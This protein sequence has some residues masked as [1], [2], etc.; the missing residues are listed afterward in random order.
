MTLTQLT[1][2][3]P[4]A[5]VAAAARLYANTFGFEI[6][7]ITDGHAYLARDNAAIRLIHAPDGTDFD[8]PA[9]Q[10]ALYIDCDDVETLW[11]EIAPRLADWPE[12][13]IRAPFDTAYGQ[14]EVHVIHAQVLLQFGS[15]LR[16]IPQ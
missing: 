9:R 7:M 11:A 16:T 5:D 6:V 10:L 3:I 12:G 8:D 1:P 13:H 4:V 14:R 2:F 15:P